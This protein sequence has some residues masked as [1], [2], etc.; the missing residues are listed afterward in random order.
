[1]AID[2]SHFHTLNVVDTCAI[3]NVLS[4]KLL[5]HTAL[6]AGC[7]FSCTA[8][9]VYECLSKPRKAITPEDRELQRRL[10]TEQENGRFQHYHLDIDDLLEVEVLEQRKNLGK[11]ELSS[12]AFAKR[13]QQ[14]FHTDDTSA[15]KLAS[16]VMEERRVQTTPHL[17]GWLYF[18]H[19]LGDADKDAIIQEH[20]SLQRPLRPYFEEMYGRALRYR[21]MA[22]S[23][24]QKATETSLDAGPSRLSTSPMAEGGVSREKG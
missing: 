16:Q 22:N 23:G 17:F 1:M 12:I 14:A 20:E 15:R 2:P 4:S 6:S 19:F 3:W 11:G 8:F 21:L 5:Y 9:V 18:K 24:E 10:R 7:V 13:T